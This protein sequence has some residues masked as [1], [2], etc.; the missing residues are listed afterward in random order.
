MSTGAVGVLWSAR[1]GMDGVVDILDA[2][3]ALYR[4]LTCSVT[5]DLHKL[6]TS[7]EHIV[8]LVLH[9]GPDVVE[10]IDRFLLVARSISGAGCRISQ[11]VLVVNSQYRKTM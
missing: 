5:S 3:R 9:V 11:G 10:G 1:V 2:V 4:A 7:A 8:Y 6:V